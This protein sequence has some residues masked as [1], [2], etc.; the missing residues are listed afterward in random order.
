MTAW[1]VFIT[2]LFIIFNTVFHNAIITADK[3]VNFPM[4]ALLLES[5]YVCFLYL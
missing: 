1:S 4:E 5:N 3:H 2:Y